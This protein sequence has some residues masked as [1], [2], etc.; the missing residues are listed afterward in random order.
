MC[1]FHVACRL[2]TRLHWFPASLRQSRTSDRQYDLMLD[3]S[4]NR[5]RCWAGM[6]ILTMVSRA[7][8]KTDNG[9][10]LQQQVWAVLAP[11]FG[12]KNTGTTETR[13]STFSSLICPHRCS[14]CVHLASQ[15]AGKRR[16]FSQYIDT[17]SDLSPPFFFCWRTLRLNKVHRLLPLNRNTP[18]L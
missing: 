2:Q 14:R 9:C 17:N 18:S 4:R 16:F 8:F 1:H 11:L 7:V 5:W 12:Q 15:S 10:R 3:R 6:L 13:N